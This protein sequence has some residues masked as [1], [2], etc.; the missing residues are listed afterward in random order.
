MKFWGWVFVNVASLKYI[1]M[2]NIN[3][4]EMCLIPMNVHN[5]YVSSQLT[6]DHHCHTKPVQP[7][8][9]H[10]C[11]ETVAPSG[12]HYCTDIVV[13]PSD[14]CCTVPPSTD[15]HRTTKV[16]PPGGHLYIKIM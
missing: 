6:S 4:G 16:A 2:I 5:V 1:G 11:L 3:I 13:P 10:Y 15:H 9:D 14:H 8:S 12:D 7:P